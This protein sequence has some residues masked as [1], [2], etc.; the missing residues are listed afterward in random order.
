MQQLTRRQQQT[1]KWILIGFG[2]VLYALFFASEAI[3][4]R[5]YAGR[6]THSGS[7]IVSWLICAGLWFAATPFVL[8]VA[9][10]FPLER[11]SWL[12]SL[13]VHLGVGTAISFLLL[14][15]YVLLDQSNAPQ[16]FL[17]AYRSQLVGSLHSEIL[18]YW[19]VIG[20]S[21]VV[22]YYRKYRDRE[23]RATQLEARLAQAQLDALKMQLHPHFLFNTLNSI[24]VLMTEDVK[25]A[26]RMLI[27][28]SELLR[29]SLDNVGTHEVSLQ[30]EL[31]FLRNYLEI[32][33]TRF[34]DR[35]TVNIE[36]E[37]AALDAR[38]PNLILQPLVENAIRHGIAPRSGPGLIEIRAERENGM[39]QLQVRDNGGGLGEK[40]PQQLL[41]GIG[42]A[43]TE[44]RLKQLYGS[45][46]RFEIQDRNGRGLEVTI[47]FPFH[48]AQ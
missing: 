4:S 18:T 5:A 23:L 7:A 22:D 3:V 33:Q 42:L 1:L 2:W 29:I 16:P 41:K 32:E 44:A 25:A 26:Q 27:R 14:A 11:N 47:A 20:L 17:R 15:L 40:S 35:L 30:A 45:N 8:N 21:H 48:Q 10:R 24:S 37:P 34:H 28:L 13:L 39:V 9:H 6:P 43:N 12:R 36:V 46:Y 38:V 31:D 19:M